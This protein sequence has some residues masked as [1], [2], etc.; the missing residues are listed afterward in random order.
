MTIDE[1]NWNHIEETLLYA[2]SLGAM[3][4]TYS[5]VIPIGRAEKLKQF[6]TN[7]NSIDV[8]NYET[9]IIEKYSGYIHLL[10]DTSMNELH[11]NGGCGAGSRTYVMNPQGVVR[12][13]ATYT[14]YGIIGNI[15]KDGSRE[16]FNNPLC[17]INS[18]LT[19]PNDDICSNCIHISFCR[20]CSLRTY[21][22]IN[23]I[24]EDKCYWLKQSIIAQKWYKR[25]TELKT[26]I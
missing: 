14:D 1:Y 13:C 7:I 25:M 20:G 4:F 16:I 11:K 8:M 17:T 26:D 22:K 12:M 18:N 15:A 10:D 19:L 23:E 6:W 21:M 5:P 9:S 2:K 3:K 24:G